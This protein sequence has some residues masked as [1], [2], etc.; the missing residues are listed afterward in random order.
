MRNPC[1]TVMLTTIRSS[2]LRAIMLAIATTEAKQRAGW[3]WDALKRAW[4]RLWRI[5]TEY[6]G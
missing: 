6:V 2:D 4:L 1:K 3:D 5:R